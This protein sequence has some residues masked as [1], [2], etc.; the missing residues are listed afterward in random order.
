MKEP[1][2]LARLGRGSQH[3]PLWA[4]QGAGEELEA[5][6]GLSSPT[7]PLRVKQHLAPTLKRWPVLSRRLGSYSRRC[8]GTVCLQV[9]PPPHLYPLGQMAYLTVPQFLDLLNG[10]QRHFSH[11]VV[12]A[13]LL[14]KMFPYAFAPKDRTDVRKARGD[15]AL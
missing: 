12:V 11:R 13:T 5:W 15:S 8:P 10:G 9:L 3:R 14:I 4:L 6:W 7:S 2:L 1:G